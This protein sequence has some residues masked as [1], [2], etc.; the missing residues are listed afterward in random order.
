[1]KKKLFLALWKKSEGKKNDK[2]QGEYVT[3]FKSSHGLIFGAGVSWCDISRKHNSNLIG[4]LTSFE[5]R[6]FYYTVK[7][8]RENTEEFNK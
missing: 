3:V 4:H 7:R 5:G 6:L 8:D 1:M 2:F